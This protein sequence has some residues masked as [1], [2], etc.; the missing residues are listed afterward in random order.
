MTSLEDE[1]LN[2]LAKRF[3]YMQRKG[4]T[5]T[6]REWPQLHAVLGNPECAPERCIR[7]AAKSNNDLPRGESPQEWWGFG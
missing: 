6:S 7:S 5:P 2:A 1:S 4:L 3:P